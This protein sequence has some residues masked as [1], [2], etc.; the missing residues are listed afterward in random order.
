MRSKLGTL[1]LAVALCGGLL[2]AGVL[3]KIDFPKDSPVSVLGVD[4][5]ESSESARGGAMLLELHAALSLRNNGARR[6]RGITLIV[7]AQDVTAGGKGSVTV[8]SLDVA[9]SESFPVRIDL[10]L[11][12]PLQAGASAP[13]V[14]GLD[15][16]LF[17]DLG[18]YGPDK[19]NSRR[20]LTLCEWEARRDRGYFKQLLAEGKDKLQREV[21]AG[22]AR[23]RDRP[24]V[25]VQMVRGR[26][27]NFESEKEI[28]LAFLDLPDSPIQQLDGTATISASE[29]RAPRLEVRNRSTR[30]VKYLEIGWILK[31]RQG[32][33]FLAGALPAE[34]SLAPGKQSPVR[35]D[36]A[37]RFPQAGGQPMAIEGM[38]SYVSNVEFA[39]GS[40]WI[41]NRA[42]L[43][44]RRLEQ[45][46][47]P[48]AEEQRL[49]QIYRKRGLTAL[50]AE[51][52][53]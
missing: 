13:L 10:R 7:T 6:I 17:D 48:S 19:L 51:L 39:D 32:R 30:A 8:T 53:K 23:E 49:L 40:V 41:P 31:D 18:F 33:E 50:I 12:R 42:D 3:P 26:A 22:I 28:Q 11:L 34:L 20:A 9:P 29:A 36:T 46:V 44:N 47:G 1:V 24:N 27:T 14:V 2:T 52:Q 4:Y 21:L 15:G 43:A 5:G 35:N 25:E 37:L 38:T 45:I 16:V